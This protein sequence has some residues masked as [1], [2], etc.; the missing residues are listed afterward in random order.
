MIDDMKSLVEKAESMGYT[1]V[2]YD[3]FKK[4]VDEEFKQRYLLLLEV[5]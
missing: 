5:K 2:R 1:L 4:K 3:Q